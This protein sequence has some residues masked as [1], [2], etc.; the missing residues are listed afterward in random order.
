MKVE[1]L[2]VNKRFRKKPVIVEAHR[3]SIDPWPDAA[4][5]A[6]KRDDITLHQCALKTGF[7]LVKTP[8]GE[9]R[10]EHGD[11][12]LRGVE[13]EFYPCKPEIFDKTYEAVTDE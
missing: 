9:M 11:W 10:G 6:V 12:L 13:G 8:E 7:I 2:N 5:E 3:I 4:W 1:P